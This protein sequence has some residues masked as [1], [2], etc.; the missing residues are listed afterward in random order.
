MKKRLL[1]KGLAVAVI[2][3]FLGF[4]IQPSI[5]TVE[6][7]DI[8][9]EYVEFIIETSGFFKNTQHSVFILK[10]Q[11]DEIENYLNNIIF[12]LDIVNSRE[13]ARDLLNNVI[14]KLDEYGLLNYLS[15]GQ[16]QKIVFNNF[17]N[18]KLKSIARNNIGVKDDENDVRNSLCLVYSKVEGVAVCVTLRFIIFLEWLYKFLAYRLDLNAD[19][20]ENIF[21]RFSIGY[22][23]FPFRLFGTAIVLL[24]WADVVEY[25]SI[26]LRGIKKGGEWSIMV[27][28]T[29]LNIYSYDKDTTWYIGSAL[30]IEY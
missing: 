28:F 30:F 14:I 13:E 15:F 22:M 10:K 5:A 11:A 4:A 18:L 8:D 26:G 19:V 16:V 3:L 17:L 7:N 24:D 6:N 2:I 1:S 9:D 23:M 27:G 25:F 20:V 29:G 12:K 21:S